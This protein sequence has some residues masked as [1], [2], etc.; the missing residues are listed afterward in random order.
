MLVNWYQCTPFKLGKTGLPTSWQ[1]YTL[2]KSSDRSSGQ[3]THLFEGIQ[4]PVQGLAQYQWRLNI[5]LEL[6]LPPLVETIR[7]VQTCQ[8]LFPARRSA[9]H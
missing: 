5:N 7:S 4:I 6:D 2:R 8:T 1:S 3:T 9:N